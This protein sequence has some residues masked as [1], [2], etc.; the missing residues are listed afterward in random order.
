MGNEVTQSGDNKNLAALQRASIVSGIGSAPDLSHLKDALFGTF[1]TIEGLE[2]RNSELDDLAAAVTLYRDGKLTLPT[3]DDF[4]IAQEE[5]VA[6]GDKKPMASL[7]QQTIRSYIAAE[8]APE[9]T[10]PRDNLSTKQRAGHALNEVIKNS[11]TAAPEAL[12]MVRKVIEGLPQTEQLILFQVLGHSRTYDLDFLDVAT[13]TEE[14]IA[15]YLDHICFNVHGKEKDFG[16]SF[17]PNSLQHE[18][19][20][21]L[22]EKLEDRFD[23]DGGEEGYLKIDPERIIESLLKK[24]RWPETIIRLLKIAESSEE[25]MSLLKT[26]FVAHEATR[27]YMDRLDTADSWERDDPYF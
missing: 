2:R 27:H 3:M 19:L 9:G 6:T 15:A 10:V 23:A 25:A 13:C 20:D 22:V 18:K 21:S 1:F 24:K 11:G 7:M 12:E 4:F 5:V 8:L 17:T 16:K 14:R 26:I